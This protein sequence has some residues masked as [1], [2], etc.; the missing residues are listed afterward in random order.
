[1]NG[2]AKSN[3]LF[4]K[5]WSGEGVRGRMKVSVIVY[6][7]AN[8]PNVAVVFSNTYKGRILRDTRFE[9]T[10]TCGIQGAHAP[11]GPGIFELVD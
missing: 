7:N 8:V 2:S 3:R 11:V 1:M 9:C 5:D 4:A 10:S 6:S